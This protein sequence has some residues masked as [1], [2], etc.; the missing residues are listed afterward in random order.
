MDGVLQIP[1]RSL[2]CTEL[3]DN[4]GGLNRIKPNSNDLY[5]AII[6]VFSDYNSQAFLALTVG[7]GS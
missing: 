7:S 6:L 2:L 1:H 5:S 3:V 4:K